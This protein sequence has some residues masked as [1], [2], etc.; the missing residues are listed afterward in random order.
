MAKRK[1]RN[2]ITMVSLLLAL[3]ALI[4]FYIWYDNRPTEEEVEE[5][6]PI[7][8]LATIDT[9]QLSSL[10]YVKDDADITFI[11]QDEVWISKDEP[12]RPINQ[13]RI[14]TILN[15]FDVI[16]A[17]RIIME[18]AEN[19]ADYGLAEPVASLEAVMNDGTKVTVKIG[20]SAGSSE[21]YYGLVNDDSTVYL[22]PVVMGNALQYNN[23]QMTA[24]ENGPDITATNITRIS[25]DY[26]D[27]EDF[28]LVYSEGD[29]LDNT[30]SKMYDWWI[31]KPYGE[32]FSADST[33]VS[34][35]QSNYTSFDYVNCVD[36]KG[37]D[38]SL[39]GLDNPMATIEIGY[40]ETRTETLETPEKD[41]ETG[42]EIKEKTY[43]DDYQF[44]AFIGN[45]DE[46]GNYYIRQDGSNYIYTIKATSIDKML[47]IDVFSLLNHYVLIPN[48]EYV[49]EISI[50]Y[51][52][53][54][55]KMSIKR[56]T[57]KN[58]DGK[59]EVKAT[60]YFNGKEVEE[61]DFKSLYQKLIAVQYDAQAKEPVGKKDKAV[62]TLKFHTFG[63]YETTFAASYVPYN[64][65]FYLVE[66]GE[67]AIFLVDKRKVDDVLKA[68]KEF[69]GEASE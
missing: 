57:E 23:T 68:V 20:N 24:V 32:G 29:K 42:E 58:E 17:K 11:K 55:D 41:P 66:K 25:I 10:H 3:T 19:L 26:R 60:Y 33:A 12:D 14:K 39:Y 65:S 37:E 18:K 69:T 45:K 51:D 44:K 34:N 40:Y 22:L 62:A 47:E 1:K 4:A 30:G 53:S 38:L 21:G 43:K 13:D 56:V 7:I 5:T 52:G 16:E 61:K 8:E 9:E 36:Y 54:T 64:D 15:A 6:T 31:L 27:S 63:D 48:I 50:E 2:A 35:F 59:D 49:D 67:N 46:D 28:E